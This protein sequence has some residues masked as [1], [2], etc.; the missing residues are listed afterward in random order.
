MRSKHR[1][2]LIKY[3][4]HNWEQYVRWEQ[5][6]AM[7]KCNLTDGQCLELK[8]HCIKAKDLYTFEIVEL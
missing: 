1:M 4:R 5:T 8:V 2:S 3:G 7:Y 6:K